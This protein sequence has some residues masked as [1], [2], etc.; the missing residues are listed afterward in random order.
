[1]C[2]IIFYEVAALNTLYF[3]HAFICSCDDAKRK[4]IYIITVP[5]KLE[6]NVKQKKLKIYA[7]Y[8]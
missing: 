4:Y 1:M 5:I 2:E 6:I 8:C 3:K 7:E